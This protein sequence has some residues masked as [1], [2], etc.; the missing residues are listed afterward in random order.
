MGSSCYARGNAFNV[1]AIQTWLRN[2]RKDAQIDLG[3]TLC[4]GRCR[5]GPILKIGSTIYTKVNSASVSDILEHEFPEAVKAN[6]LDN[7][8]D[9]DDAEDAGSPG[10]TGASA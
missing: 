2:H 4:E 8:D 1:E 6:R 9:T 10:D 5:E 3:G 7:A